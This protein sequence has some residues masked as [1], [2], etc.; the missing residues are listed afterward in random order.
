MHVSSLSNQVHSVRQSQ[1][2]AYDVNSKIAK[3]SCSHAHEIKRTSVLL[4]NYKQL[5]QTQKINLQVIFCAF[6]MREAGVSV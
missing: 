2:I 4:L 5:I 3:A 6:I 1:D